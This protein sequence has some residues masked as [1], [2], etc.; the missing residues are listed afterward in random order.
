MAQTE[1]D[2]DRVAA[3][4]RYLETH[5][6]DQPELKDVAAHVGLSEYHFQRLF[7]RWAGISP[8]RFLQFLTVQHARQLLAKSHSVLDTTY[9]T[10]LSSPGRLHDLFVTLTAMTPGE[11]KQQG[12]GLTIHYGFHESPFGTYLLAVT[13]RGISN[14][15]FVQT[16]P[17]ALADLAEAWPQATLCEDTAVTQPIAGRIFTRSGQ[18]APLP[19]LVKGTNFQVQVWQAL[20]QVPAGTAVS[21]GAI[22][23][24]IGNPKAVRAV[25]TAVAHNPIGYLIPCHRVIR[26]VGGFGDY[27]WGSTRK[28]AILGW[29]TARYS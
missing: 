16:R 13:E 25:G 10:G 4:I 12:A 2:Y 15:F 11:Y 21:Y 22:A 14:L 19:L 23:H 5:R 7:S 28:K 1:T 26:S 17:Q 20:L 29:E 27:R 3:A 6:H 8:K 9:E 24:Q 18:Q